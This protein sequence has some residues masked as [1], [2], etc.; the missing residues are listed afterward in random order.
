MRGQQRHNW[1]MAARRAR[2]G[3]HPRAAAMPPFP[4]DLRGRIASFQ[5]SGSADDVAGSAFDTILSRFILR[6][7][8]S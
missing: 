7:T 6:P 1:I 2:L 4:T 8:Q 5:A 3:V